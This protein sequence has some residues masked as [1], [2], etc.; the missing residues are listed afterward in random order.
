MSC[1]M[2]WVV[3]FA[4]IL[5]L[6]CGE[7]AQ[8]RQNPTLASNKKDT[9][10]Q[11]GSSKYPRWAL[12]WYGGKGDFWVDQP[13][14]HPL[15]YFEGEPKQFDYDRDLFGTQSSDIKDVV[16]NRSIGEINGFKI[17]E[18]AHTIGDGL[19]LKMVLVQRAP[20]EFC[21]I[22]QQEYGTAIVVAS[23]AYI[24]NVSSQAVL[25][26]HD[27]VTGSGGYWLEEYWTFD[28]D[29]PIPLDLGV[30]DET[31]RNLMGPEDRTD[32]GYQ[33]DIQTLSVSYGNIFVQFTLMDH[34]LVVSCKTKNANPSDDTKERTCVELP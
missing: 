7:P 12:H 28:K 23:P 27:Q 33:F 22:F 1:K 9:V 11:L 19:V 3:A 17:D 20:G 18:V 30:V 21:E 31:V 29:G 15:D 32:R 5:L 6:A 4:F 13:S 14:C 25:A 24:R 26:T 2:R 34:Q 10:P 16:G 8:P